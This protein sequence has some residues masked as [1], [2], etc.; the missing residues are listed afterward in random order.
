MQI[1]KKNV[2]CMNHNNVIGFHFFFFFYV[3]TVGTQIA[4]MF[5]LKICF[6]ETELC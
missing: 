4:Q 5:I 6:R 3:I 2:L 1:M